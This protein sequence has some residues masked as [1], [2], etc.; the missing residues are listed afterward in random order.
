MVN[1]LTNEHVTFI[2]GRPLPPHVDLVLTNSTFLRLEWQKPFTWTEVAD[3][4]NY[5][6]SMYN[7]SSL[8]WKNSTVG[9]LV[10]SITV[11]KADGVEQ[12]AELHFYVSATN[13]VGTSSNG[14]VR[15]GFPVGK[16]HWETSTIGREVPLG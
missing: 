12:C 6:V 16:Y 14:N 2:T 4:T 10:N 9:P 5:T 11:A 3:I 8:E 7:S 15:G 13:V 1:E